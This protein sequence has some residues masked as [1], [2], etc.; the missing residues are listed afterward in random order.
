MDPPVSL[1]EAITNVQSL[2]DIPTVDDQPIIEGFSQTLDYRVN[3]DTNFEDRNAYVL[4]CSKY[5]EEATRHGEFK[6]MLERGFNHAGNLYTWRCCSR[7]VPMAKSNDQPNRGEINETVVHVLQPEVNK[8]YEFMYFTNDAV[9]ML[10][11][12]IKRLSHP[13][14]RKDFV[15]EAYLLILGKFLNMLAILDELKN[16]K[17]SIKNDFSTYRRAVQSNQCVVFDMQQMN[18]LSIFLAT[19]NNIKE[20]LRSDI[21]QIDSYEEIM[22]DV[23]NNCAQFYENR[24]YVSPDE[25]HMFVKVIAFSLYLIDNGTINAIK[26]DQKKKISIAR[27]DRIFKSVEVVPLYGDMQFQ[28]FS[29]IKRTPGYDSS[30][31]P[32]SNTDDENCHVNIVEKVKT[33]RVHHDEYVAHLARIKNEFSVYDKEGPRTDGENRE[34]AALSLSGIQLLCSWTSDVVETVSW[35]LLNPTNPRRNP[36]CPDSAESYERA[37][38]YNY[39]P[40]EKAALIETI[41]MIKG[42]QALIGKMEAEFSMAI[43]RHIYAELQEFIQHT[44]VD[45]LYK[46]TKNKK[47]LLMGIL[48]SIIETSIDDMHGQYGSRSS[49]ITSLKLR[50]KKADTNSIADLRVI[51]RAVSPSTTQLYMARTMLES[52][53]SEKAGKKSHRKDIDQKH[54]EKMISFLRLSYHWTALLN[55]SRTLEACCDLSQLWFREFYLEMTMG[56]RIQFPIEMSIPWILTDHILSTQEPALIECLLYQ[57]DLYNDAANY[58]LK[59]FKKKFLYDECEAEVNLCFDQFIFKLSDAV[60]TYYKQIAACMLLDKGFKQECQ[61]IGINIRTPPAT[62]YE[63]LLRQR[64]FQLLGRQI[65]LNKLVTQRINVSLLRS[66]D[67]AISRFESEGLFWIITLDQLIDVNRLCHR[68]L[69]NDLFSLANFDNLLAEASNQVFANNGR[70]TLH[71]CHEVLGDIVPNFCFNLTTRRF[72]RSSHLQTPH[73]RQK[74][75]PVNYSYEFGSRSLNAA[76]SNLCAM[77]SKFIGAPHLQVLTKLMGY[78][79]IETMYSGLLSAIESLINGQLNTHVRGLFNLVPKVCK[80]PR[81]DYGPDAVLQYYLHHLKDVI[82]YPALKKEFCQVLREIGNILFFL[83]QM[84]TAL[85]KEETCDLLAAATYTN[86]IPKPAAKGLNDLESKMVLLE[87][88]YSRIQI[89]AV[90]QEIG[91]EKQKKLASDNNILT[92]ERICIALNMFEKVLLNVKHILISDT[93]WKG[94][95]PPNGVMWVDECVEFHRIWSAVQ[96]AFCLPQLATPSQGG[97]PLIEEIFGDGV[98]FAGCVLI[99]LLGQWRR[100]EVF[101]FT[102]HLLRVYRAQPAKTSPTKGSKDSKHHAQQTPSVPLVPLIERIRRIQLINNQINSILGNCMQQIEEQEE[103]MP[104]REYAPPVAPQFQQAPPMD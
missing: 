36:E 101:D 32:L 18:S 27:L 11:N 25:K 88:K 56:A 49:D 34:I 94:S 73:Q 31:W 78:R 76:F 17:A 91:T 4:G 33:I 99:R 95:F 74:P 30:K 71:A 48:T 24:Y 79:G 65:D 104:V 77:Y 1:K 15:S 102:N 2:E 44:L 40:A 87:Q 29:F 19:Q 51:R 75:P 13:E 52:L 86:V 92:T 89:A 42:V 98:H 83:M 72:I 70:I 20:K 45:P 8:L 35:K 63:I 28:P 97:L 85:T 62:R 23:I 80:L 81:Y 60:F 12:E 67:A 58:S 9:G 21:Q 16:M 7:A 64:H 55:L 50:K 41:A 3:F 39:S 100:F 5:I 6:Q 54:I 66:L 14:K 22:S 90:I 26:L 103:A 69:S 37:T 93:I 10:C 38:R 57:L 61:R 84:E 46:A 43:R 47:D 53:I 68:L 82:A 59:R 96:F